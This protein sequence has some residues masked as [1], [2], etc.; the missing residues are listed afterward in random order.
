[1][2]LLFLIYFIVYGYLYMKLLNDL[3]MKYI[4]KI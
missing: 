1:M 2:L 3:N 4:D